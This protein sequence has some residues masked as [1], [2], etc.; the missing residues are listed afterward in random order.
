MAPIT[1]MFASTSREAQA[2]PVLERALLD[3][4]A[5]ARE[6]LARLPIKPGQ[7]P[8]AATPGI[9]AWLHD[10][11]SRADYDEFWKRVP[12]WQPLEF[13][14]EYA[15]IPACYFSGWWDMYHE[16]RFYE[17]FAPRKRGPIRLVMGPWTHLGN[18]RVSGDVD[19]G[20][21]A[22]LTFDGYNELQLRW[23]DRTL[24]ELDDVPELPPVRIFVM[25]GGSG[26][27][28]AEGR[29]DHGGRWRD[30]A[31]WPLARAVATE[32]RLHPDGLLSR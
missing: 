18:E 16:E 25:G 13:G 4:F 3:A 11:M 7:N 12:L 27:R 30:E 20:P 23:F 9:E 32:Y 1:F 29:L 2:D 14:D 24:K 19:F 6:W 8:L 17:F 28:T 5:N 22:E 10:I 26:R 15:D 31:E 21:D